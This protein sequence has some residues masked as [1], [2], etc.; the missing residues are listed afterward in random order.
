MIVPKITDGL[1]VVPFVARYKWGSAARELRRTADPEL[2]KRMQERNNRRTYVVQKFYDVLLDKKEEPG[3]KG[4]ANGLKKAADEGRLDHDA[5]NLSVAV[6]GGGLKVIAFFSFL[7]T[8]RE[9][10]VPFTNYAGTSAGSIAALFDRSGIDYNSVWKVLDEG[11]CKALLYSPKF[12]WWQA[13]LH[14]RRVQKF[15]AAS[16]PEGMETFADL[17]GL[18]VTSVLEN[19]TH[20]VEARTREFST[21][22]EVV[23]S[24]E[25]DPAMRLSE[26]VYSSMCLPVFKS[27]DF[28]GRQFTRVGEDGSF[29]PIISTLN[30][31]TFD[32]GYWD[33]YPG[34]ILTSLCD[35]SKDVVLKLYANYPGKKEV[36][37]ESIIQKL[38]SRPVNLKMEDEYRMDSERDRDA[39]VVSW[40]IKG[41]EGVGLFDF[42][43]LGL[44]VQAGRDSALLFM[45]KLGIAP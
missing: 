10:R 21:Y 33:N 43:K 6:S 23:F 32:G 42:D 16:L 41:I 11:L 26:G 12:R 36:K 18:Y 8:L 15:F 24:S 7:E 1:Y 3:F 35:P 17:P 38:V 34:N 31:R 20:A 37:R 19:S 30:G 5:A 28:R 13:P 39:N 2:Y 9:H 4:G 29:A 27:L 45:Q 44:M 22:E 40:E 14:G 25:F